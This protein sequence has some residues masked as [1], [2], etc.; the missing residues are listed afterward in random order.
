MAIPQYTQTLDNMVSTALDT[1]S[2]DPV[3]CL[4]DSGEKFLTAA[5]QQ[6]RLFIVND[7][8]AVRHPILYEEA[9]SPM[10]KSVLYGADLLSGVPQTSAPF[11]YSA[12]NSY[13]V[14]TDTAA[15]I[16][17]LSRFNLHAATRNIN[18]PQSQ[19]PGNLIDYVSSVV[20]ANMMTVMNQEEYL[21]LLGNLPGVTNA[22]P[23]LRGAATGDAAPG[24]TDGLP[25]SLPAIMSAGTNDMEFG[26]DGDKTASAFAGIKV[27]DIP[28]WAPKF[29]SVKTRGEVVSGGN[30]PATH[31]VLLSALSADDMF[32]TIQNAV[33]LSTYSEAERPTHLYTSIGVFDRFL[34][35]LRASAALPDPV[36]ANM[37]KQGTISFAGLTIDWSRYLQASPGW[38]PGIAGAAYSHHPFLGVN[39]N[40]LRL[41]TVRAGGL[42]SENIGFIQQIGGLQPHPMKTNLFKRIEW[43]RCW[44]VDNGRRSFFSIFGIKA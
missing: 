18:F 7:A 15:E 21:F 32:G 42:S 20:R 41:N 13:N 10:G 34:Q 19:P 44:S 16:L 43:K 5:A 25:A 33:L 36:M 4:T 12:G 17:T 14:L 2:T 35:L 27:D 30:V 24:Y 40:S 22:F 26:V 9:S 38:V 6:G 39:W 23:T 31:E 28:N 1:Y 29:F 37:G 11:E 3:N 8:E